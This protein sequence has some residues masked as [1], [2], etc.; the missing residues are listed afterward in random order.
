[1][2]NGKN[3]F[4]EVF[5]RIVRFMVIL[6]AICSFQAVFADDNDAGPTKPCGVIAKACLKGG[7]NR[8]DSH[9]KFW[10]D[11]MKQ[12]IMVKTVN[13]VKVDA[14]TVG[15][16]RADKIKQLQNDLTDFQGVSANK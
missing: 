11:C 6:A 16:C 15:T 10:Q 9:K 12:I 4:M 14:S 13:G 8:A 5:M 7:F 1:M 3:Q 2:V